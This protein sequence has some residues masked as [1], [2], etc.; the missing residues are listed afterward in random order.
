MLFWDIEKKYRACGYDIICGT[1]EAGR[2][3]LA[4]PVYAA[5]CILPFGIK[6]TGLNDSKKLSE[7]KRD[8]L[9]EAITNNAISYSIAYSTVE[10]IE[11]L[12]ILNAS[13]LAMRRAVEK[14]DPH[15]SLVLA[16]G[17]IIRGFATDA[18]AVIGG[19]T[20]SPSIA[21]ASILAKVSR[22]RVCIDLDR[23]YPGYGFAKHKGYGTAYHRK[24]LEILGPCPCH[25]KSFLHTNK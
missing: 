10:E 6:I 4:G 24:M 2:G 23:T 8:V 5:A 3:P 21:A 12:N 25:R 17:N 22:D 1:D 11:E 7:K 15:P 9:F 16:D 20:L 14:L 19:D 13:L 18:V